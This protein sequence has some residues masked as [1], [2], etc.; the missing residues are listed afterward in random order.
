MKNLT[1]FLVLLIAQICKSQQAD[2]L[3]N[4]WYLEKMV[5]SNGVVTPAPNNTEVTSVTAAFSQTGM[6]TSVVTT[7]QG[8]IFPGAPLPVTNST[9]SYDEYQYAPNYSNCVIP[10]N[11]TFEHNYFFFFGYGFPM[12]YTISN[13]GNFLRLTLSNKFGNQAV[14][15]SQFLATAEVQDV[16]STIVSNPVRD[17]LKISS[18]KRLMTI[19]ITDVTGKLI[20][21]KRI[22]KN[23]S[24]DV[25][26]LDVQF[27]PKGIYFLQTDK[28][29]SA[30]ILK[31]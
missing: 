15:T 9:L 21:E 27:L 5:S 28:L 20:L 23:Q 2:L 31:E 14:Y 6:Q 16:P 26:E 11:C 30:K 1:I 8:Y 12:N 24:E 10:S 3:N 4:T 22:E 19:K 17:I 29:S 13:Q 18:P 25:F 7:F